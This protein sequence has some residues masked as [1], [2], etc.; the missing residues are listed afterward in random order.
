MSHHGA[1]EWRPVPGFPGYEA[2]SSGLV[3]SWKDFHGG[4]A[5]TPR[6]LSVSV[7]RW[8]YLVI[9]MVAA[10]GTRSRKVFVHR[11]VAM[12]FLG[13]CPDGQEVNHRDGNKANSSISNLE[14]VTKSENTIHAVR[15]GLRRIGSRH[16]SAKLT[17]PDVREMRA[18]W[19]NGESACALAKA[20]GV[21]LYAVQGAVSGRSWKHV[22]ME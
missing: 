13:P 9:S 1:V 20:Y 11:I 21:R 15:L 16:P 22:P 8:G 7:S 17:E 3:R 19:R 4:R 10:L 2:S 12:A 18:R 6:N 14:Y 5:D